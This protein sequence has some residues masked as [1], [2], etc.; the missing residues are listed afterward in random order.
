MKTA[1]FDVKHTLSDFK[2]VGGLEFQAVIH[3]VA[4]R[5]L[6]YNAE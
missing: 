6:R 2:A 5:T 3:R 4:H 1:G